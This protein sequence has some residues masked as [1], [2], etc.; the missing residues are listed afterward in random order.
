L[1]ILLVLLDLVAITDGIGTV[2]GHD[3]PADTVA[4]GVAR[5]HPKLDT[6]AVHARHGTVTARLGWQA[7]SLKYQSMFSHSCN[8]Q[9]KRANIDSHLIKHCQFN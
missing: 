2:F 6:D 3:F 4:N 8:S 9:S 1:A 7:E 5:T